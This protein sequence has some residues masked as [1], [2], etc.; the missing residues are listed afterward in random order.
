MELVEYSIR[1]VCI[2][3]SKPDYMWTRNRMSEGE[4]KGEKLVGTTLQLAHL[5][6]LFV[7]RWNINWKKS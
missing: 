5:L 2:A 6:L 3:S 7:R 4:M 1:F